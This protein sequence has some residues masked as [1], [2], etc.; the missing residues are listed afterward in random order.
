MDMLA[1]T[2][3]HTH[4]LGAHVRLLKIPMNSTYVYERTSHNTQTVFARKL[5]SFRRARYVHTTQMADGKFA[6]HI[7][8][9]QRAANTSEAGAHIVKLLISTRSR[10]R[11]R[12]HL[13][14]TFD[15]AKH[16][17]GR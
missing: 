7:A 17:R 2:Q 3:A 4:A 10:T 9:K 14:R 11:A 6:T 8:T 12:A 13:S 1:S 15:G 16:A 5:I